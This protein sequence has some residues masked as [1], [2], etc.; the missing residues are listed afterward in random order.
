M[1]QGSEEWLA[2]RRHKI[3]ASEA[4]SLL[5]LDYRV[6]R[7]D[8]FER[9]LG[10]DPPATT[11]AME[12]GRRLEATICDA[13]AVR[14]NAVLVETGSW[15]HPLHAEWLFAS[16]DRLIQQGSRLALLEVKSVTKMLDD[17]PIAHLIQVQLQLSCVPTAAYVNY[18]QY[19]GSNMRVHRV[20]RDIE[21]AGELI[22]HL[23]SVWRAAAPV[24]RGET[25]PDDAFVD[26]VEVFS[27]ADVQELKR[28]AA[29][30]QRFFV[31]R[32]A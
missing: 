24:F 13:F 15:P 25:T 11:A 30:C 6:T 7:E 1:T 27:Y 26:D 10:M 5:R 16:P 21:F 18:A 29:E 8:A 4:A 20:R 23:E 31:T 12:R 9:L 32:E 3:G 22:H 2:F 17:V 28:L 14:F 19:D